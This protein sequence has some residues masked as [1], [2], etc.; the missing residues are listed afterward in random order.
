MSEFYMFETFC[1]SLH[2]KFG[3]CSKILKMVFDKF[4]K[5]AKFSRKI[6]LKIHLIMMI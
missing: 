5:T 6:P 3:A 2:I 1:K 4:K